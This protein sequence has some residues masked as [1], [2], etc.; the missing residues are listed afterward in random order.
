MPLSS[1]RYATVS[2]DGVRGNS[3]NCF[4]AGRREPAAP[5]RETEQRMPG[6]DAML[7]GF[8]NHFATEAVA[9]ALPVGRN[10][11]QQVAVRPLCRAALRHR[12]HRAARREPPA[13]GSIACA[14]RRAIRRSSPMHGAT[15]LRSAP[16]DEVPPTPNRLRWDPLPLPETPTDFVDG[17]VTVWRQRRCRDRHRLSRSISTPRPRR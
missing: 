4:A 11:P 12:L 7:T 3:G 1:V 16:F 15:L 8:G 17:L 5:G 13:A 14:R 2:R 9:G 10:S 6:D